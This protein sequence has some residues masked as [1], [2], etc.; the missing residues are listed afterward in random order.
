M[1][2]FDIR[3]LAADEG[4]EYVL[5]MADLNTHACYLIYGR[6][7]AGEAGR[8]MR[9]GAGHEEI[10]L[11]VDGPLRV[12]LPTGE[13]TLEM[14]CAVHLKGDESFT[15]SN[16]TDHPVTYVCAGGHSEEGHHHGHSDD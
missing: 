12:H 16:P 7:K 1:K 8:L 5:G 9:P 6:L 10:L 2:S 4:G 13:A 3:S 11:A 14:G 15:V